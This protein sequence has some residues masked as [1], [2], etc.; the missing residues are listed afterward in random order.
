MDMV[1]VVSKSGMMTREFEREEW[2]KAMIA[3]G[4]AERGC[5]QT[6]EDK[7][8]ELICTAKS[9]RYDREKR[10]AEL[11][12]PSEN[13][14]VAEARNATRLQYISEWLA[15]HSR[16]S[17]TLSRAM[18]GR[19]MSEGVAHEYSSAASEAESRIQ[20]EGI[21]RFSAKDTEAG[22]EAEYLSYMLGKPLP[23]WC[24]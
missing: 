17:D 2:N 9:L 19:I 11:I 16:Y 12:P 20:S 10:L 13:E 24:R 5:G 6:I 7:A 15:E 8:V 1:T 21:I 18:S 22:R 23:E 4:T 14:I 3:A